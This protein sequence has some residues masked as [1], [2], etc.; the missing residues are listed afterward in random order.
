MY[1]HGIK[2]RHPLMWKSVILHF[3]SLD[4]KNRSFDKGVD[5]QFMDKN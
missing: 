5:F 1:Q 4:M 2:E 3:I